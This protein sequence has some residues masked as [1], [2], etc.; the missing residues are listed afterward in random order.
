MKKVNN[1]K[2]FDSFISK[3]RSCIWLQFMVLIPLV[4]LLPI[5]HNYVAMLFEQYKM[6]A[7]IITVVLFFFYNLSFIAIYN[8]G[9]TVVIYQSI[10]ICSLFAIILSVL[11]IKVDSNYLLEIIM[12]L[13]AMFLSL[14]IASITVVIAHTRSQLINIFLGYRETL[15]E[16]NEVGFLVNNNM[17]E[18]LKIL[19]QEKQVKLEI[20]KTMYKFKLTDVKDVE[21]QCATVFGRLGYLK[22]KVEDYYFE[23]HYKKTRSDII[24]YALYYNLIKYKKK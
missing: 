3:Y 21:F 22:F 24:N 10:Y 12:F 20:N 9:K 23:C 13:T 6:F 8:L 16:L 4:V 14:I 5:S 7:I 18:N 11:M 1:K 2:R 15:F 19:I 17:V